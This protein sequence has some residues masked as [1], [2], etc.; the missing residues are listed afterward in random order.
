MYVNSAIKYIKNWC[1]ILFDGVSL[2]LPEQPAPSHAVAGRLLRVLLASLLPRAPSAPA[3][4]FAAPSNSWRS[5]RR[6]TALQLAPPGKCNSLFENQSPHADTDATKHGDTP[7][8]I[9]A[10]DMRIREEET[11]KKK[12][13]GRSCTRCC[14]TTFRED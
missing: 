13:L 2:G 4:R 7:E 6:R 10:Q 1:E 3:T 8:I 5:R 14:W 11:L 9:H 12:K